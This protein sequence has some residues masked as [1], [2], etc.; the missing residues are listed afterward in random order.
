MLDPLFFHAP[1]V[2]VFSVRVLAVF[3][4][5]FLVHERKEDQ[6][7]TQSIPSKAHFEWYLDNLY[8][9]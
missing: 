3:W 7:S 6:N 2:K 9:L 5:L 8:S 1:I 4:G